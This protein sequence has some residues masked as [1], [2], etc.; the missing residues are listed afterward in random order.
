MKHDKPVSVPASCAQHVAARIRIVW[1]KT[2]HKTKAPLVKQ[3]DMQAMSYV[4]K[5]VE[6]LS[7]EMLASQHLSG[8]LRSAALLLHI[9]NSGM[10]RIEEALCHL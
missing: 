7:C 10:F 5:L 3:Y 8:N 2:G 4:A 6:W 1:S 9:P